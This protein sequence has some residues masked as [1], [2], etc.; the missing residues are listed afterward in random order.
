MDSTS[1]DPPGFSAQ[2]QKGLV[3][4]LLELIRF[5]HTVFALPFAALAVVLSLVVEGFP[6]LGGSDIPVRC[7]GV[8]ICM[9]AARSAA[10]AFNRLVDANID[11]ANPR[12]ASRHIPSGELSRTQVAAFFVLM[13]V[14]FFGGCALFWPNW[15]PLALAAFVLAW[16]C[17][18]S[19]AKRFTSAAH[20]W[21]GIAL[22]I[23][24]VCAWVA[25]RGEAVLLNPADVLPA[26]GLGAA[27]AF[28]VA[29]FDIIYACQDAQFDRD[30]KLHSVPA[31]FG[32]PGALRIAMLFHVMMLLILGGL[33]FIFP[34]LSLSWIYLAG[35]AV[36]SALIVRQHSIVSADDMRRVG[37]AFFTI[38]A[39]ISFGLCAAA[40]LDGVLR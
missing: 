2:P 15:L 7:V 20:I 1:T 22:A 40:A 28:W 6:Q 30:A 23:S 4:R 16:I 10:M 21:L 17:G 24:P 39:V 37:E 33:P 35:L 8:L 14:L 13:C 3:R 5:S 32:V 29:G 27:I 36:V 25:M 12:T 18:Y 38:N 9:V 31:R 34:Q 19:L 11:A 26:V